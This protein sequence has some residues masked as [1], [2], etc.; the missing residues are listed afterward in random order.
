MR[1]GFG[2]YEITPP[3]GVELAGYGYYL[4]RC[5]L[6]VR[7]PLYVRAVYLEADGTRMLILSCDLLGLSKGVCEEVFRH[8]ENCG[9]PREGVI[10]VS[11]HTHTG[12][13]IKYHEGC[14]YVN[15]DYVA[16]LG[17]KLCKAVDEAL[18]DADEVT[19]I[20]RAFGPFEGDH[21]YNR[22][23]EGGPV[24]RIM[25]GFTLSRAGSAPI[26]MISAACH[27]VFR[28]R[29]TA[30]SADFAGEINGIMEEK[31][32]RSIYINGLCGDIDP[33]KSTPARTTEFASIA[34]EAFMKE[35]TPLS[36]TLSGTCFSFTLKLSSVTKEEIMAAAKE[37]VRRAGGPEEPAARVALTWEREM[38]E[39]LDSLKDTEDITCKVMFLGGVPVI[40]LP[41]EGFTLIGQEVRA[42]IGRPD[43]LVLGCAE[44][45][46]G[47]LP[48][49]DDIDREAYAA[50]ESTFL[51]KRFPVVPGEAE[52]LGEELGA[53]LKEMVEG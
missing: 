27:G 5:A 38:L 46:L 3:M 19:E 53:A 10:I 44:E 14:G 42:I 21:I 16:S 30:V 1:A 12:P 20:R 32:Y 36:P 29:S 2:K 43:A 23:V 39:K 40:A 22:T 33:Y 26:C 6:S 24:D 13:C 35:S 37:A 8:A 4:N 7:D 31:G 48:T 49:K 11:I 41:F 15:D 47:Y 9:I 50:L 45:L 34:V 51:Y 18:K 25:R 17:E 28:G 52:R